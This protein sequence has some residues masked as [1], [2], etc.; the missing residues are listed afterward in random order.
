MSY[1]QHTPPP[2]AWQLKADRAAYLVSLPPNHAPDY[3]LKSW[4]TV[5]TKM[6]GGCACYWRVPRKS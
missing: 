3:N 2:F 5:V 4:G 6:N 1:Q